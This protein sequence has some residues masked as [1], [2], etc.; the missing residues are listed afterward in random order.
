MSKKLWHIIMLFIVFGVVLSFI[1]GVAE[2][3][4]LYQSSSLLNEM[5][6]RMIIRSIKYGIL[7]VI[8]VF[9]AFFLS[10]I[11]QEWRIHPMQYM[12]V[13]SALSLFYLLFLSFA[14]HIGFVA[15]Y[16][17]GAVACIGLLFWYLHFVLADKRGVY[18]MVGLLILAYGT[19][20]VLLRMQQYNLVLGSCLLF[21]MLFIVM[22]C[23]R[24][25]DWY[26]MSKT[27]DTAPQRVKRYAVKSASDS[28]DTE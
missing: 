12:L 21:V 23:T 8:M 26:A 19:M 3:R 1:D 11:L 2:Q 24:N 5:D 6:Y 7:L 27:V 15:A 4:L 14:E 22:Y 13:G 28:V 16:I 9:S 18:T 10:E 17:T 20:F 25:V